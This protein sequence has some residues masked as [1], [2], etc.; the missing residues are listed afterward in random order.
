MAVGHPL[1][2]A[3]AVESMQGVLSER[4]DGPLVGLVALCDPDPCGYASERP[5]ST[6]K[7]Q[8]VVSRTYC[9]EIITVLEYVLEY[10]NFRIV[11]SNNNFNF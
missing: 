9:D 3:P 1:P 7:R 10:T 8:K 6:A 4:R 11:R 5:P 2:S